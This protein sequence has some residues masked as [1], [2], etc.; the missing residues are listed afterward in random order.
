MHA[1]TAEWKHYHSG[2][3]KAEARII[4]APV[5][6]GDL[7]LFVPG[8]P[9]G[10]AT[11]YEQRHSDPIRS[12]EY[13]QIIL[14]HNGTRLNGSYA[15]EMLNRRQFPNAI[16]HHDGEFIGGVPSSIAEW[17]CEP[18]TVL[19]AAGPAFTNITVIGHSFGALAALHSLC[20]LN[21]QGRPVLDRVHRCICLAPAVGLL[22]NSADDIM[23]IWSPEFIEQAATTDKIALNGSEEIRKDL[24]LVY[25]G[26]PGRVKKLPGRV[27]MIFVPVERDEYLRQSDVEEFAAA[28]GGNA[29]IEVDR[30]DRHDPRHNL[31]A[32]DMPNYPTRALLDLI[33]AGDGTGKPLGYMDDFIE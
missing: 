22:K 20:A 28:A 25:Q 17:L 5:E 13:S 11:L 6:S 7:V 9:G 16:P 10:G 21:E 4:H 23:R 30:F 1:V 15:D 26:L 27:S 29:R 31:D 8:F 3:R 12:E 32:H 24:Q 18:Q 2:D 19:E 14:R 33:E